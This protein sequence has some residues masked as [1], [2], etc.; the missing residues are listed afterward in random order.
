[1]FEYKGILA[2]TLAISESLANKKSQNLSDSIGIV[3]TLVTV[4]TPIF[5]EQDLSDNETYSEAIT[6]F[7]VGSGIITPLAILERRAVNI[8]KNIN[9]LIL[10]ADS[11]SQYEYLFASFKWMSACHGGI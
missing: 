11:T 4:P 1:M 6:K 2:D 3:D 8:V 7:S 10:L 9:D 5:N